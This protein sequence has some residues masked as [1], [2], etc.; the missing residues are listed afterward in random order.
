MEPLYPMYYGTRLVTMDVLRASFERYIHPEFARRLFNYI[1]IK[2]GEVGIGGGF[3][4]IGTQPDKPGF[5][6]EGRT[7]H[8]AQSFPSGNYYAAVD[9]VVRH[10]IGTHRAPVWDQCP[11]QGSQESFKYGVHINVA[12][13]PWH[14][15]PIEIDGY[16]SWVVNGRKDLVAGLLIEAP[17]PTPT[18]QPVEP[19]PPIEPQP[20]VQPTPTPQEVI[21]DIKSRNLFEGMSGSDIKFFQRIMN[22]IAGQ[23]LTLDGNYGARTTEAVR[24]WQKFFSTAANPLTADG[25]LGPK[26][27]KS[28]VEI[29]MSV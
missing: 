3:R 21:L 18:P 28:I 27:Q 19:K 7:F 23:N 8:Q 14:M 26:T 20:P 2:G 10:T 25:Q 29:A 11:R 24:N 16:S 13:E 17:I 1:E 22:E 6:P 12:L 9:L 5:A 15:Q 4:S